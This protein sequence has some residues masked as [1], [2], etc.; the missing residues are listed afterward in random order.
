MPFNLFLFFYFFTVNRLSLVS[1]GILVL[2]QQAGVP[3][4]E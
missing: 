4:D 2:L 3:P 1:P